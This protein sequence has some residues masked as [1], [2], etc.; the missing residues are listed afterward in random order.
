MN[1]I[2]VVEVT[3]KLWSDIVLK[4]SKYDFYHT[5]SYHLL[6]K[7]NRPILFIAYFG[8]D[9]IA[10]PL[11]VRKIPNSNY[12]DCTSV[13]GY[14]GPISNLAFDSISIEHIKCFQFELNQYFLNNN[15]VSAFS[16]LH[17]LI[18]NQNLFINFGVLDYINQTV[19]IDLSLNLDEQKKQY[20]K[21]IKSELN[22]L[23]NKGYEIKEAISEQ[24]IYAFITIY[25]KTMKKVAAT[26]DYF[27]DNNY[28]YDFLNN[29]CFE[30]K[31]LLAYYK[32]DIC[33]GALF[34]ITNG[35]MQY[36]LAGTSEKYEKNSPMKLII[37]EARLL[38]NKLSLRYLH[39]GGGFGGSDQDTLFLFKSGFSDFRCHF[40]NWNLIVNPE[41]YRELVEKN[42]QI[43]KSSHYFPLYRAL[44]PNKSKVFLFGS[45]GHA[46]VIIDILKL[47]NEEVYTIYDDNPRNN[48]LLG[49]PVLDYSKVDFIDPINQ[50]IIA[51]GD[52]SIRKDLASRWRGIYKIAI[53][54]HAVVSSYVKINQGTVVMACAVINPGAII[55]KHV[56]INTGAIVEHDCVIK[57]YVHIS[58][59][60]ALAGNVFVDEGTQVGINSSVRQGIKIGKWA[61]IGAGAVV[62]KDVP[63]YAVVIGNPGRILKYNDHLKK[64]ITE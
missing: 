10:L 34:T 21:S 19:A 61:T 24:E 13:Y 30:K 36:H 22:Q 15:I 39:L 12:F 28:F 58:P 31:I 45:S 56:I 46:K 59:K 54:P 44:K 62:V 2:N 52:N 7:Q 48:E 32:G 43:D 8:T 20:R 33:A 40:I 11:I 47:Q 17:P 49:I 51:I 55:G 27:F 42:D 5:Q 1:S 3:D 63:D 18:A 25:R 9:F 60:A 16:R 4:S 6:E 50:L 26:E 29:V 14:C 53:H 64:K 35:I 41:V 38:A 37:D 23:R 57:D